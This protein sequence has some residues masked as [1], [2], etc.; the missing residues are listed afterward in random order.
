[1][2]TYKLELKPGDHFAVSPPTNAFFVLCR[3]RLINTQPIFFLS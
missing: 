1:M 2:K 3:W